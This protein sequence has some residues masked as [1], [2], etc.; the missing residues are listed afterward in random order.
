MASVKSTVLAFVK[1]PS[2]ESAARHFGFTFAAVYLIAAGPIVATFANGLVA[3][4]AING[5]QAKAL[6]VAAIAAAGTTILRVVVPA[7]A[8][9]AVKAAASSKQ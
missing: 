7:I 2:V 3:G 9:L 5:D 8:S 1:R 4:Q 6:G